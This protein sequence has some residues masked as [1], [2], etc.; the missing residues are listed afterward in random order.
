MHDSDTFLADGRWVGF[1][2]FLSAN[3]STAC[4]DTALEANAWRPHSRLESLTMER[5]SVPRSF[6]LTRRQFAI[7]SVLTGAVL[8]VPRLGPTALARQ[9]DLTSGGYPTIDV[10]VTASAYEG[11]PETLEAGRYLLNVTIAE[12]AGEFGGAVAFLQPHDMTAEEFRAFLGDGEA[13][14]VASPEAAAA[15]A[16]EGGGE[17][18]PLPPF[19]YQSTF[20]GGAATM[21]GGTASTVIDLT[22][23]EWIAWGDDPEAAQMPVVF[24]VTGEF[25]AEV[26]EPESDVT[27]TLVDFGIMVEGN[28]VAG[29]HVV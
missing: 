4:R 15:E 6:G 27:I 28:L 2:S 18:G 5:I 7:G 14:P 10:T 17:E 3:G 13:P 16:E 24:T 11:V 8:A 29:E 19:V 25:P 22:E 23:G 9:A 12:D 20:A 1:I 21:P 26:E